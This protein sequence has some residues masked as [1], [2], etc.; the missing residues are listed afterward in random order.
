MNL[1]PVEPPKP[2]E[3]QGTNVKRF[4]SSRGLLLMKEFKDVNTVRC[5]YGTKIDLATVMISRMGTDSAPPK[6]NYGLKLEMT[7]SDDRSDSAF[8]DFEEFE[9]VISALEFISSL[10]NRM[11]SEQRD[12]AEVTYIT[13]DEITLGFFQHAGA[14]GLQTA[15]VK[16]SGYG[17]AGYLSL[18]MLEFLKKN[19]EYARDYL[20]SKGATA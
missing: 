19:L 2:E 18:Q 15:Y 7:D 14:G 16:L 9:E 1:I 10:A 11:R 13:K 17:D 20:R 6:I 8:L 3:P 5:D 4:L 12:Y